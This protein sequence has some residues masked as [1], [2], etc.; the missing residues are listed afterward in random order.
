MVIDLTSWRRHRNQILAGLAA[1]SLLLLG[2]AVGAA[3]P[4]SPAPV[5]GAT[6]QVQVLDLAACRRIALERQPS[7]AAAQATLDA[8]AARSRALEHTLAVPILGREVPV[9]RHQAEL[10]VTIASAGVDQARSEA[11]YNVTRAYFSAVYAKQQ[12]R[13]ANDA[14]KQLKSLQAD[15]KEV[16]KEREAAQIGIFLRVVEGRRET[17]VEGYGRAIAALREAM[18]VGAETCFEV[19]DSELRASTANVTKDEVVS[20]A[21]SRRGEVIQAA[22]FAEVTDCEIRAQSMKLLGPTVRTFAAG[23][24]IHAKPVPAGSH[25]AEYAPAAVGPEMPTILVG[26]RSDRVAQAQAYSSRAGSV[27]EK[28]RNLVTLEAEDAYHRWAETAKKLPRAEEAAREAKKISDDLA[29]EAKK[30]GQTDVRYSEA[31]N[32][33]LISSQLRLEA[34]ETHFQLLLNLAALERVTGGGFCAGLDQP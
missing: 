14:E 22:T 4:A 29:R 19:A 13:V 24:D 26:N 33:G 17:A 10:G 30:V 5:P 16:L 2:H 12:L 20:L 15:A 28:T 27:V 6:V 1:P 32:A 7:L 21:L 23:S 9:R 34:N 11:L 3:E 25:G 8:A 18:G 31:M